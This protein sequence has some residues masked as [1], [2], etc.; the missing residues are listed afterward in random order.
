M[1]IAVIPLGAQ[2]EGKV[3]AQKSVSPKLPYTYMSMFQK[4]Y[5]NFA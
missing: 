2:P 3:N 5:I 1:I 4:V